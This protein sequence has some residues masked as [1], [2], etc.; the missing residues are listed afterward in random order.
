MNATPSTQGYAI[1]LVVDAD[2]PALMARLHAE[3]DDLGLGVQEAPADSSTDA[4]DA[5]LDGARVVALVRVDEPAQAIEFRVRAPGSNELSRDR[6]A[7]RPRRADVAAVA[8]VELLR[9]RLIKLG[10]VAA[11]ALPP[12]PLP[13]PPPPALAQFPRFSA[14][15]NA[16]A[17]YSAG[18][19]GLAPTLAL[20]LR[21][22]PTRWL[23]LG[24]L[25]AFEPQT[26]DFRANEGEVHARATLLG[27]L[28]DFGFDAAR[29]RFELGGGVALSIFSLSGAASAPFA[30][31][32]THSY[33][34]VPLARV[35][36]NYRLAGPVSLRTQAL[37][38]V[39]SPRVQVRFADR[40]VAHWGRPLALGLIGLEV[41]F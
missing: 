35:G 37:A 26:T 16:G 30:G 25:G 13:P 24:T 8:T 31:R 28:S 21:A 20:G 17:W 18:G 9:A 22:H 5:L 41:G 36:F 38:G 34:V 32:D 11:P 19:F 7:L 29:A 40:T 6:V 4:L 2:R 23:A 12:A 15:V 33:S 39:A 14:D 1:V 3:L 27:V 10:V